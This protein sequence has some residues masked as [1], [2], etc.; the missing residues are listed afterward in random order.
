MADLLDWD[1]K[2][3]KQQKNPIRDFNVCCSKHLNKWFLV[4][5][6]LFVSFGLFCSFSPSEPKHKICELTTYFMIPQYNLFQVFLVLYQNKLD[7]YMSHNVFHLERWALIMSGWGRRCCR[8]TILASPQSWS[9]TFQKWLD[10]GRRQNSCGLGVVLEW[11]FFHQSTRK[12]AWSIL[13]LIGNK[14]RTYA[15]KN[16]YLGAVHSLW[17]GNCVTK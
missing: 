6:R 3:N 7:I 16:S 12:I 11:R 10:S 5:Q 13:N 9:E 2:T 4:L 1:F 17:S 15:E 8:S 14:W